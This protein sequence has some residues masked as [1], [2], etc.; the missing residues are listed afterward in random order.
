MMT[1]AG[2]TR[3]GGNG[4]SV[5]LHH[6]AAKDGGGNSQ[7]T[8]E[9]NHG[10]QQAKRKIWKSEGSP[11]QV[12]RKRSQLCSDSGPKSP[13][14]QIKKT[15]R[16]AASSAPI[17]KNVRSRPAAAES[18]DLELKCE[19]EKGI[20][21]KSV[22][23]DT[24][25][26]ENDNSNNGIALVGKIENAKANGIG[27]TRSECEEKVITPIVDLALLKSPHKVET[28]NLEEEEEE[29]EM[30]EMGV[31]EDQK[32]EEIVT[33]EKK[34]MMMMKMCNSPLSENGN[35]RFTPAE[36]SHSI[37]SPQ[38]RLQ[39][40][41][42]LVMWR[43]A[44]KSAFI[45]G[46]GTFII[47]SSSFSQELQFSF[48][49][50]VSYLS[51]LYLVVVFLYKSLAPKREG[52]VEGEKRGNV[53][54]EEEAIRLLKLIL[55]YVNHFLFKIKVLF[56]GD[57]ATTMKMGVVLF[58]LAQC[59][60]NLTFSK[61]AKLG[62]F[63]VFIL[64]KI[65]SSYSPHLTA[66]GKFWGRRYRDTWE[67]CRHKKAVAFGFFA[68]LWNLSSFSARLWAAFMLYVAFRY[69]QQEF[70][71]REGWDSEVKIVK[72]HEAAKTS[73]RHVARNKL[74]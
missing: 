29:I 7:E 34:K 24:N 27:E 10:A 53:V 56:S 21:V 36:N 62:F 64:P 73:L 9:G 35:P 49:S 31:S 66:Y 37:S 30:K 68:L 38:C 20:L 54:G 58:V 46:F 63:G 19:E 3:R 59:G 5:K 55:P 47:I 33:D 60:T 40:L 44:S 39:S 13:A 25:F 67:S 45:F 41:V 2:R 43:D 8:R 51:L 15:T 50:M 18:S 71:G 65:A 14:I 17:L 52:I 48:I 1:E 16:S 23:K 72:P 4:G 57:P 32:P 74:N 61:M 28:E 22:V 6:N 26:E 11:V 69:Y 42:D 12:S 70:K